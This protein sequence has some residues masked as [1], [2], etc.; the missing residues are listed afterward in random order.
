LHGRAQ[1]AAAS[2]AEAGPSAISASSF[3][4]AIGRELGWNLLRSDSLLGA[5]PQAAAVSFEPGQARPPA[6][7]YAN[8][9]AEQMGREPPH[10]YREIL[11]YYYPG[12]AG[13]AS[14]AQG[15]SR[16]SGCPVRR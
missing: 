4:F 9:G 5:L 15:N 11:A 8:R 12:Y 14:D 3:R 7:G 10:E 6:S 2:R 13:W 1:H 16:G